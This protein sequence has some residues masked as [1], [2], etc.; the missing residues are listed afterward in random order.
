MSGL[1]QK[2][3]TLPQTAKAPSKRQRRD[4]RLEALLAPLRKDLSKLSKGQRRRNVRRSFVGFTPSIENCEPLGA[5][6]G[7][8]PS[9]PKR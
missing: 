8:L 1:K 4:A 3:R 9:R 6:L 5:A 2:R 7:K